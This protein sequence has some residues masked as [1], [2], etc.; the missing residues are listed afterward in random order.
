MLRKI[1]I[2]SPVTAW[3]APAL[4]LSSVPV[5]HQASRGQQGVWW[6]GLIMTLLWLMS[7]D[8]RRNEVETVCVNRPCWS[9]CPWTWFALTSGCFFAQGLF[10]KGDHLSDSVGSQNCYCAAFVER[11]QNTMTWVNDVIKKI[12]Y[13]Q[14][15]MICWNLLIYLRWHIYNWHFTNNTIKYLR[16]AFLNNYVEVNYA[17]FIT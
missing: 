11:V 15:N 3:A 12:L 8:E 14:V 10:V 5:V 4:L 6:Q 1:N 9:L 16:N 13:I 2:T 17:H 7:G